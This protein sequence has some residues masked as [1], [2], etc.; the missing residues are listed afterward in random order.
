MGRFVQRGQKVLVKPNIC[1]GAPPEQA[2]TTNPDVVGALVA[3]CFEAGAA[4]VLVLD[5]PFG[6]GAAYERS[7][8]ARAVAAA[9][10]KMEEM[11]DYKFKDVRIP[12]GEDLKTISIYEEALKADVLIDVPIAKQHGSARL[13]LGIKNLMGIVRDR[14][15]FHANFRGRLPDLLLAV[16]PTLTVVD[17][18]RILTAG[19]PTGGNPD[20]V[21]RLDTVIASADVV[22]ADA[23]AT[24]LFGKRP[25]YLPYL[26]NA[27]QRG[28]GVAD[29]KQLRIAEFRV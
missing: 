9:G 16:K 25:D 2:A 21:K 13:T 17:A 24:T 26:M 14:P 22:A 5:F 23:Y 4:S 27:A 18:V 20:N 15:M 12:N 19:G 10:G 28:M 6:S 11:S 8:I 3:M 7:G 29:L 1:T